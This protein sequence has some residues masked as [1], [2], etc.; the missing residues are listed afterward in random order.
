[1]RGGIHGKLVWLMGWMGR[2]RR[3][4]LQPINPNR[5]IKHLGRMELRLC[6]LDVDRLLHTHDV[7]SLCDAHLR[8]P[9]TGERLAQGALTYTFR[10]R[11][12]KVYPHMESL[13]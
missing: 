2:A 13:V 9:K 1:M 3:N 8:V 5:S 4:D 7:Q 6:R 11:H 10:M 12:G